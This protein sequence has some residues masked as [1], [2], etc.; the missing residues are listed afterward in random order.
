MNNRAMVIRPEGGTSRRGELRC[1]GGATGGMTDYKEKSP[2]NSTAN[3]ENGRV[4]EG[5]ED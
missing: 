5:G 2:K 3:R 4:W 1:G